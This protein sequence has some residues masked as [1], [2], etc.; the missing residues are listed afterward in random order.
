MFETLGQYKILERIG[1]GGMGDVYR[2]RDTRLGRT[3]AIKVLSANV[4]GDPDRRERFMREAR[5]AAA[6]SHPNIA[7]LYE[8]GEDQG[9]LFLAFEFVPGETLRAVVGGRP[10][11]VR[12][13]IELAIQVADALADAHAA[14]IVHRDIKPDN[15]IV[16][17][18]GNAKIL[19]FGLATWTAGG[20]ER[21][22]AG[23]AATMLATKVGTTLGTAAYMSPEQAL[24]ERIDQRTDIFSLGIVLF[25]MLTGKLPFGGAT[26]TAVALQIVQT[27][28]PA[29]SAVNKSV[30]RELDAIVVKAL[31]KNVEQ[32]YLS[33]ATFAADLRS[34]LAVL[35]ARAMSE[36]KPSGAP[37]GVAARRSWGGTV[38]GLLIVGALVLAAWYERVEILRIYRQTIGPPPAPVIAVVPFETEPDQVFFADGLADD[39]ITR[40]GQTPGLKVI[41]RSATRTYRGRPPRDIARELGAA[42][43]LTGSVRPVGDTVKVSL[44][45]LDPADGTDVW[46][47]QFTRDVKDIFAVQAE[48]ADQVAQALRIKLQPTPSSERTASRLVDPRAYEAYLRGRD[49]S[50]QRRVD[51]AIRLFE[52]AIAADAG[53]AEAHAGLAEALFRKARFTDDDLARVSTRIQAEIEAAFRVDPDLPQAHHAAALL[54]SRRSGRKAALEHLRAALA[55]DPSYAEALHAVGDVVQLLL[56]ERAIAFYQASLALDPSLEAGRGDIVRSLL[57]LRRRDAA[58]AEASK[59]TGDPVG[60]RIILAEY[61]LLDSGRNSLPAG[62]HPAPGASTDAWIRYARALK[63]VGRDREAQQIVRAVLA[64]APKACEAGALSGTAPRAEASSDPVS[65][66]VRCGAI[67]AAARGDASATASMID[68]IAQRADAEVDEFSLTSDFAHFDRAR[69]WF[70]WNR[71]SAD[72]R[73]Q[74][75]AARLVDALDRV[76]SEL[77][78]LLPPLPNNR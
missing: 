69:G 10:M 4:A 27:P 62:T 70:P 3:V 67:A 30:P 25:E 56:P 38:A 73:V 49:A 74:A 20:A 32:R 37:A 21:E 55:T 42:V 71:V 53:L 52:Q 36:P 45:L 24:G 8:V 18:K 40:L 17:P 14:G 57:V 12:R 41:G 66:A 48:V 72:V 29:P 2:A 35:D 76:R 58:A 64:L 26:A 9:E 13:A 77:P 61:D 31:E 78:S 65:S 46:T 63:Q 43:V 6:L 47:G 51:D 75:A 54:E 5:A 68:R 11:N 15:I 44:E 50:A 1:A 33:A 7:A 59:M 16:T 19:D 28:A 23:D 22:Q 39:L 34:V 60:G